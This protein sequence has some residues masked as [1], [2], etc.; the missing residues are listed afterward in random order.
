MFCCASILNFDSHSFLT[1]YQTIMAKKKQTQIEQVAAESQVATE[2]L[3]IVVVGITNKHV[4]RGNPSYPDAQANYMQ[5]AICLEDYVEKDRNGYYTAV[6]EPGASI[7]LHTCIS[8]AIPAGKTLSVVPFTE[9]E[10]DAFGD[11]NL[12]AQLRKTLDIEPQVLNDKSTSEIMLKVTNKTEKHVQLHDQSI[13]AKLVSNGYKV[14]WVLS[15][16]SEELLATRMVEA[17][18]A[19]EQPADTTAA[20]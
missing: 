13:L 10:N 2:A 16:E 19:E 20:E 7:E 11:K 1:T 4:E 6:L 15:K 9:E 17:Q 8:L 5:L 18:S 12:Y 3:P 14:C